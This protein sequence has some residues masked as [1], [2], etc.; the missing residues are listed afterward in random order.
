[1]DN[2]YEYI[3]GTNKGILIS[4]PITIDGAGHT[5]NGNKLSRMFNVTADNV[6]IRNL[7]FVNGNAFGQYFAKN[8][9]GGAIYWSGANGVVE[10]C[11]FTDNT[12]F[13]IENDPFD[14]EECVLLENGMVLYS[15]SARPMGAKTNEGG[16]IVWNGTNGT[17]SNCI[18]KENAVGYSNAGGAICWRGDSGRVI[19]SEFYENDAWC[20][21]AIAWIGDNGTVLSSIVANSTFFDGGIYWFGKNGLVRDSILLGNGWKSALGPSEADVIADYNFWGD[22]LNN[23]NQEYKINSV[24]K[25]LVMSFTHNGELVKKGQKIVIDWNITNLIDKNG[26]ILKYEGINKSGNLEY[27]AAK[28]GYLD[29]RCVNGNVNV[30]VDSKDRIAGNDL[31]CY[32]KSNAVFKVSISDFKGKVV[33]KYV[34]FTIKGKIYN[35]KT[36]K[37]G[38][39]S[40][41]INLKPGTYTVSVAYGAAHVKNKITVK[42]TLITKNIS[43]NAGKSAKFKVK[44]L[45]SKG[46]AF[47]KKTVKVKFKGKTYKLKTNKNGIAAFNVPKNLKV[48]KY[49]IKTMYNGLTNTNRITVKR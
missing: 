27:T 44:V 33:G 10:N 16:A 9:G 29:I 28:D 49:T 23:P 40:L 17:V 18:F 14:K 13:G 22:S 46:K 8:I 4:K 11:S 43:K 12:G 6:T 37:N 32:Y 42:T 35:V 3:N 1:M 24:T 2:D 34:K 7:N 47:A 30:N 15:M 39:A 48:G 19:G 20:G 41:K 31:K 45:N 21:S 38:V 5:L 25:W 36:D 26:V